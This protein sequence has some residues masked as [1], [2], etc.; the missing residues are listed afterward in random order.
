MWS[1]EISVTSDRQ[2]DRS[3]C[4][5]TSGSRPREG[6]RAQGYPPK[7]IARALDVRPALMAPLMR[8]IA[9]A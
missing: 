9:A 2:G 4:A 6:S 8:M 3:G 1:A 7:A 5:K